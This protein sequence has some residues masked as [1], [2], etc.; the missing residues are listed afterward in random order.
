[1]DDFSR[2]R[3]GDGGRARLPADDRGEQIALPKAKAEQAGGG[4]QFSENAR[5][6]RLESPSTG[7]YVT[8]GSCWVFSREQNRAD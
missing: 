1:M 8:L 6:A 3:V 2:G 5:G 4:G 7:L